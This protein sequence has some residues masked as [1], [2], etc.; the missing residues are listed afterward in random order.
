MPLMMVNNRSFTYCSI[1]ITCTCNIVTRLSRSASQQSL[2]AVR[3]PDVHYRV[4]KSPPSVPILSQIN[5]I[6]TIPSSLPKI[7]F[8]IVHP[9]TSWS[10]HVRCVPS[11]HGMARPQVANGGDA[12]QVWGLDVGLKTSHR[13]KT[14]LLR[15]IIRS[16]GPGRI[17]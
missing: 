5:P 1:T 12:L 2:N 6:H 7:Q 11:H 16:L 17:P 9:P 8:N 15:K 3:I 10:S 13:K 4:H 14:S